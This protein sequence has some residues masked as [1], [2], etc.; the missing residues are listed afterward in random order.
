MRKTSP[1]MTSTKAPV[2]EPE[3]GAASILEDNENEDKKGAVIEE[4][5]KEQ[6][7]T[8]PLWVWILGI[9]FTKPNPNPNQISAWT[10][11]L[12]RGSVV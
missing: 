4:N 11:F 8:I 12:V 3:F 7:G 6:I 9:D 1:K 10:N 2:D 5:A